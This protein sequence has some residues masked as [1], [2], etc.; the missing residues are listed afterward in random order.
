[1]A[2]PLLSFLF[3]ISLAFSIG[4]AQNN[5][6]KESS[7]AEKELIEVKTTVELYPNPVADNLHIDIES[8]NLDNVKFELYNIIGN[9][10][11]IEVEQVNNY[12][13][14]IPVR[15]LPSGYYLLIISDKN[16]K[17]NQP[18]KFQKK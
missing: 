7:F 2:K 16:S 15:T 6:E 10:I 13:Y 18:F 1:M 8:E 5:S 17:Y 9:V 12:Q 4:F 3:F 14:K 11:K